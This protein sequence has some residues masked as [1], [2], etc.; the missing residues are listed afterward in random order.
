MIDILDMVEDSTPERQSKVGTVLYGSGGC[1]IKDPKHFT[2]NEKLTYI[3]YIY[4]IEGDL[5]MINSPF[6]ME[7]MTS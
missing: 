7:I 6:L 2:R 4:S 5:A 3:E 1:L